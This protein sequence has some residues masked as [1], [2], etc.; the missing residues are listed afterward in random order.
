MT[1]TISRYIQGQSAMFLGDVCYGGGACMGAS[2]QGPSGSGGFEVSHT[3]LMPPASQPLP[4][5]MYQTK[6]VIIA[7]IITAVVSISVTIFCFQTKVRRVWRAPP[8]PRHPCFLYRPSP[9]GSALEQLWEGPD[10][11]T[12]ISL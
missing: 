8:W 12:G 11:Y 9:Q 2:G 10:P 3:W 7:M 6:A 4:L 1:G 5:S